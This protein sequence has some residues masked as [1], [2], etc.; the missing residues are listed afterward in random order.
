VRIVLDT[1]VLI[2]AF[3]SRRGRCNRLVEYCG[4]EHHLVTSEFILEELR[5]KFRSKFKMSPQLAEEG[6]VAL[7]SRM[8]VVEPRPLAVPV[9]RDP[10]DD[11]VLATALAGRCALIV[12]GDKDLLSLGSFNGIRIIP[13][14]DF[15]I[16]PDSSP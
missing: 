13:P 14:A 2:A 6:V 8:E 12:T 3:L 7:T 10:D 16:P 5:D 1:N 9:S 4:R 15:E 11:W